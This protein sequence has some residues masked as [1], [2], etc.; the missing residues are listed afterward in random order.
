MNCVNES[1]DAMLPAICGNGVS[2]PAVACGSRHRKARHREHRRAVSDDAF[3]SHA[4]HDAPR[5]PRTDEVAEHHCAEVQCESALARFQ[6]LDEHEGATGQK[7]EQAA[8]GG[9]VDHEVAHHARRAQCAFPVRQHATQPQRRDV[10]PGQRLGKREHD[11]AACNGGIQGDE[12][13]ARL[14]SQPQM[15]LGAQQRRGHGRHREHEHHRRQHVRGAVACVEVAH[16]RAWHDHDGRHRDRLHEACGNERNERRR[17]RARDRRGDEQQQAEDQRRLAAIAI[18]DRPCDELCDAPTQHV[19]GD[20]ELDLLG[21]RRQRVRHRRHRR[22]VD[23]HRQ[24]RQRDQ[25][26]EQQRHRGMVGAKHGRR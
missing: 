23:V 17:Q 22:E 2:A 7:R 12:R 5:E 13:E 26:T 21:R 8:G 19:Y 15:Q 10:A 4:D 18:G 24:R 16:D 1:S 3:Q 25:C 14:P 6:R 20:R 9:R 11:G